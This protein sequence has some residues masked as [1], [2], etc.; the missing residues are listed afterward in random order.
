MEDVRKK[1]NANKIPDLIPT[2]NQNVGE[3]PTTTVK[4][5]LTDDS[6]KKIQE[7]TKAKAKKQKAPTKK[8]EK[9]IK[10][11]DLIKTT[12]KS[13]NGKIKSAKKSN[14][15]QINT[16]S[17]T[18]A[19]KKVINEAQPSKKYEEPI[20]NDIVMNEDE[21]SNFKIHIVNHS[22]LTDDSEEEEDIDN[23]SPVVMNFSSQASSIFFGGDEEET[24]IIRPRNVNLQTEENDEDTASCGSS[25]SA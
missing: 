1:L 4:K 13:E 25:A 16:P 22:N 17:E 15:T 14:E 20:Y 12:P 24:V 3:A 23:A 10:N 7:K 9:P 5:P 6:N 18:K 21:A 11:A 8:N 2:T 19:E